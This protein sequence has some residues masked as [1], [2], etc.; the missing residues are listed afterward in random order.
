MSTVVEHALHVIRNFW[1]AAHTHAHPSFNMGN[2]LMSAER[3]YLAEREG[4]VD[5]L[6]KNN[7]N[8]VL[9]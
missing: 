8:L 4:D 2:Q 3:V 1:R 9:D 7:N 5:V 6:V